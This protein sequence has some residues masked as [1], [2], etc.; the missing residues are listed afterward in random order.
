[1]VPDLEGCRKQQA[2]AHVEYRMVPI[3]N[4]CS[5]LIYPSRSPLRMRGIG[6]PLEIHATGLA[7]SPKRL[8]YGTNIVQSCVNSV[9]AW[10]SSEAMTA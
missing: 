8:K 6:M 5:G 2:H 4:A 3:Y 1:M 9:V 7:A 10:N